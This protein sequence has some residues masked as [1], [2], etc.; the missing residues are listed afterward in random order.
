MNMDIDKLI[1]RK[2]AKQAGM[3]DD[4]YGMFFA[5][6]KHNED[7]VDLQ[8]FTEL[9]IRECLNI[10]ENCDGDLGFAIFKTK[11]RFGIEE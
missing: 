6:V 2:L 11:K 1:L 10:M 4:K 7:G 8:M 3:S 9:I 5:D